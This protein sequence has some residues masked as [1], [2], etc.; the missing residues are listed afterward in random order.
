MKRGRVNHKMYVDDVLAWH[1]WPTV[2]LARHDRLILLVDSG[3]EFG[4][5]VCDLRGALRACVYVLRGRGIVAL[6]QLVVGD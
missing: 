2:K 1:G 3:A 4:V 5:C 6:D